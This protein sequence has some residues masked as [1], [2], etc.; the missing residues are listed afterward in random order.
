M[1]L[2]PRALFPQD[3]DTLP[4]CLFRRAD[5]VRGVLVVVIVVVVVVVVVVVMVVIV[6]VRGR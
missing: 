5:S 3:S 4:V 1:I 2:T 6:V